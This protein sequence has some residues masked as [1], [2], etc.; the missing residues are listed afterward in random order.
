M[1]R[2]AGTQGHSSALNT[3]GVFYA[4]EQFS[5]KNLVLAH[6][7]HNLAAVSGDE[8]AKNNRDKITP[9]LTLAKLSEAQELAS[10]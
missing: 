9:Q 6:I 10:K 3:L 4:L 1:W 7:F 5:A 2:T 8:T